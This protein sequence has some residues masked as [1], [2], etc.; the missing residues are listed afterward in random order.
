M[1]YIECSHNPS[2]NS[3]LSDNGLSSISCLT[4]TADLDEYGLPKNSVSYMKISKHKGHNLKYEWSV[5]PRDKLI[6]WVLYVLQ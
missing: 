6:L 4:G 3:L 1:N 2:V 5:L